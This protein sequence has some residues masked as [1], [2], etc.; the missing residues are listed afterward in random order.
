MSLRAFGIAATGD[1]AA[2]I[3]QME[4]EITEIKSIFYK[5]HLLIVGCFVPHLADVGMFFRDYNKNSL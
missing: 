2:K 4:E 1:D 3:G 5:G